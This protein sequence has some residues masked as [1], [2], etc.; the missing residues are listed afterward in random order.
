MATPAV[1]INTTNPTSCANGSICLDVDPPTASVT[2]SIN[3]SPESTQIS[4]ANKFPYAITGL[5][6]GVHS[7]SVTVTD[8]AASFKFTA[9]ITLFSSYLLSSSTFW[10]WVVILTI[11]IVA[12]VVVYIMYRRR[13][14]SSES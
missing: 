5:S 11:C 6:A 14:G 13:R 9:P 7:L 4:G 8:G 3:G 1:T 10:M 2:Y 12:G